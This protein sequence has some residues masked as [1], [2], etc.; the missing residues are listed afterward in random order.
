MKR[1]YY[2]SLLILLLVFILVSG[3]RNNPYLVSGEGY[4]KVEGGRIWYRILG[5]GNKTPL[6]LLH[7]GPGGTSWGLYPLGEIS[8]D[9]PI[10]FFDQLGSG[11]SDFH[12]D[13]TL[14]TIEHFVYQVH[15][16]KTALKLRQFYLYGHSWGTTLAMEYYLLYPKGIK[17]LIFNSPM[18]SEPVWSSDADTLIGLLPDSIQFAIETA[19]MK[20][21][22]NVHGYGQAI[23]V[24]S[25]NYIL[26][27]SYIITDIDSLPA[28]GN[29]SIYRYMW[30]PSEFTATGTLKNYDITS[31]LAEI[32]IPSLFITGEFDEARPSSVQY[33]HT[34]VPGSKFEVIKDAGHATMH[35][36]VRQNIKSITD[37]LNETESK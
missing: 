3:C 8:K 22:Y 17:A 37:F 9:R 16:L 34:L 14:M 19:E 5:E 23:D 32:R 1:C 15:Q 31:R 33:F 11:H 25:K 10:I 29:D 28:N 2:N 13:T 35:D 36:N 24:Y 21:V 27:N 20:G 26:R 4:I 7:G 12:Y 18:F 30:G 6:M